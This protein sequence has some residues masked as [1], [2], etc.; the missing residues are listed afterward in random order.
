MSAGLR[1]ASSRALPGRFGVVA[2]RCGRSRGRNPHA[3]VARPPEGSALKLP[4]A[5]SLPAADIGG[6]AV[7]CVAEERSAVSDHRLI[8]DGGAAGGSG[9]LRDRI[10]GRDPHGLRHPADPGEAPERGAARLYALYAAIFLGTA[11]A[12]GAWL[13]AMLVWPALKGPLSFQYLVHAHSHGAFFGWVT[14][15]LFAAIAAAARPDT[16]L[17]ARLRVHAHALAVLSAAAILSFALSGYGVLSIVLAAGHVV[18]WYAFALPVWQALGTERGPTPVQRDCYRTAL[19]LLLVA[20]AAT[21]LPGILL[22]RGNENPWL[23][24]LGVKLFL[25]PFIGGWLMLGAL[26][27]VYGRLGAGRWSGWALR[28]TAAGVLPATLLFV[29]EPAPWPGLA[30]LGHA[31]SLLL[32]LGGVAFALDVIDAWPRAG[33][34]LRLAGAA[35]F[36]KATLELMAGLGIGGALVH[37]R[38]IVLAYLHLA[39]LGVITPVLIATVYRR[40]GSAAPEDELGRPAYGPADGRV[41]TLAHGVGLALMCG[42][43]V[44]L[45]W[46]ALARALAATGLGFERL[47][48]LAFAGGALSAVAV[49][50]LLV[51]RRRP[52]K[53]QATRSGAGYRTGGAGP[54][55]ARSSATPRG[56]R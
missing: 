38:S 46:P 12:I 44:G 55:D 23:K 9:R 8:R 49:V 39:L 43:L 40:A 27:A 5:S 21:L 7:R 35:A 50:A 1:P 15:A 18:L 11:V 51:D 16:V 31:G 20:G 34:L 41:R 48:P 22:A 54:G 6:R 36:L 13:R 29:A 42:A 30:W 33:A 3:G 25:T 28:L 56:A 26:G 17:A 52:A 10:A 14:P 53:P 45:G 19:A 37:D 24:E 4:T 47:F 2:Q 32:G